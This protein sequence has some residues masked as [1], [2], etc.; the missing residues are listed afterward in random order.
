M[1]L[2]DSFYVSF[3][4]TLLPGTAT[5][6]HKSGWMV[7]LRLETMVGLVL[8]FV[9]SLVKMMLCSLRGAQPFT[10]C[11]VPGGQLV[12]AASSLLPSN[13]LLDNGDLWQEVGTM[14]R[15][16]VTSERTSLPVCYGFVTSSCCPPDSPLRIQANTLMTLMLL[17]PE[18]CPISCCPHLSKLFLY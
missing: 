17:A 2:M 10:L 6:L 18:Y 1:K 7:P 8:S 16:R 4:D 3:S 11:C 5:I 14:R 9:L 13:F 15:K 12:W